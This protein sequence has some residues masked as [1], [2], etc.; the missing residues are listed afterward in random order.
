MLQSTQHG[1]HSEGVW[2]QGLTQS[3]ASGLQALKPRCFRLYG[4][5]SSAVFRGGAEAPAF[6]ALPIMALNFVSKYERDLITNLW[7]ER[8]DS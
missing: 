7:D 5:Q 2:R 8:L 6:P 3:N 4:P 1:E